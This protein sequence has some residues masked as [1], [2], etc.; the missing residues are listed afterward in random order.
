MLFDMLL[1]GLAH[2]CRQ[3]VSGLCGCG[4]EAMMSSWLGAISVHG[5]RFPHTSCLENTR[6]NYVTNWL[7]GSRGWLSLP[8]WH[9]LK[10]T[11]LGTDGFPFYPFLNPLSLKIMSKLRCSGS[12]MPD[13]PLRKCDPHGPLGDGR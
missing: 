10:V 13:W 12:R 2:W 11:I 4:P 3:A 1:A 9:R 8:W 5:A 6:S 7:E